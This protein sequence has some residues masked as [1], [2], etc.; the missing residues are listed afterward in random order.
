MNKHRLFYAVVLILTVLATAQMEVGA[1]AP[2]N[3]PFQILNLQP[4]FDPIAGSNA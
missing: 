3:G 2:T 1:Q 4:I